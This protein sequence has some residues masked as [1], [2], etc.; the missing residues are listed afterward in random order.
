MVG[1]DKDNDGRAA[2]T[3]SGWL[4]NIADIAGKEMH[5]QE[6]G[7]RTDYERIVALIED[8]GFGYVSKKDLK[9]IQGKLWE[10]RL[11][12]RQTIARALCWTAKGKRV[13]VVRVFT[14]KT[15]RI[16]RREIELA[17]RRAKELG[18]V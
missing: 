10:M 17:L 16:P 4:V 1:Q 12:G 7:I 11:R 14:K 15:Q 9:H 6:R 13:I 8:F 5:K 18:Y 2:A 3:Q